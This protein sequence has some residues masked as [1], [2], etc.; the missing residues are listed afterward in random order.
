MV[1]RNSRT[2]AG[3]AVQND[4]MKLSG[5]DLPEEMIAH[6]GSRLHWHPWRS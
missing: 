2:H 4:E 3:P 1:R 6:P 5:M